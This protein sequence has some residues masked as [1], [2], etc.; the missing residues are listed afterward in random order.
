M[1]IFK[2]I[3]IRET[4]MPSSCSNIETSPPSERLYIFHLAAMMMIHAEVQLKSGREVE[5]RFTYVS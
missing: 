4:R 2:P 5:R 3:A 1:A